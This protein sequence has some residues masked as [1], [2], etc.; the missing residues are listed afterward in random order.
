MD[1]DDIGYVVIIGRAH[2]R[3]FQ[4]DIS[5]EKEIVSWKEI[6]ITMRVFNQLKII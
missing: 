2:L 3:N 6:I 1:K 5:F 4:M